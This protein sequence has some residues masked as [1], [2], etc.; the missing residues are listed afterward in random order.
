MTL[1]FIL[2][3]FLTVK[4]HKNMHVN[5][6][7]AFYLPKFPVT[8]FKAMRVSCMRSWLQPVLPDEAVG[9]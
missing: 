5:G 9:R 3:G 8:A 4:L 6:L 2:M 1:L 7:A